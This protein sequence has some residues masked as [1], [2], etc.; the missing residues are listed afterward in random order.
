MATLPFSAYSYITLLRRRCGL[1][2][3]AVETKG[4]ITVARNSP[5]A[6]V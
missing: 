2:G 4:T 3:L 1:Y 6:F 5:L